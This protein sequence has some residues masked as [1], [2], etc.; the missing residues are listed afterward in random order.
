MKIIIGFFLG[1]MVAGAMAQEKVQD[2][3]PYGV[4]TSGIGVVIPNYL[5][6]LA[7][8]RAPNDDILP[9]QVDANG[10]VICSKDSPK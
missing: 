6:A 7:N 5:N 10:Y 2:R 3:L 8:A 1:L 9:I 4:G